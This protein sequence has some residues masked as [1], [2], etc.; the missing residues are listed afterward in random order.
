MPKGGFVSAAP[1][2]HAVDGGYRKRIVEN[3][4]EGKVKTA[5]GK[6]APPPPP[7]PLGAWLETQL[8]ELR[9][10]GPPPSPPPLG[11]W[12]EMQ[13]SELSM[14]GAGGAQDDRHVA[15]AQQDLQPAP[16]L[17]DGA[18]GQRVLAADA[19]GPVTPAHMMSARGWVGGWVGGLRG[20]K[21]EDGPHYAWLDASEQELPV[22]VQGWS[23]REAP[24]SPASVIHAGIL[25][26]AA[27]GIFN[28][29]EVVSLQEEPAEVVIVGGGPHALA[30]LAA[31][32]EGSRVVVIDPGS[33]F[34]QSW[35]TRFEALEISHL[36]SPAIAHPVA[37]D[38]TALVD[39]AI[40]EGRTSELIE[41]PVSGSWLVSTDV[42]REKWLKALP[43]SALF[44]DFC[45]S[46]AAK[47]PHRFCSGTATSVSK[48][49]ET[50]EFRVHYKTTVDKREHVVPARA[51]ILATGPVGKW[52]IPAPFEP[53]LASRL[54]LHTEELL[55]ES[56]GTLREEITR[57]CADET[58][59]WG[60]R[61]RGV[62][63]CLFTDV[64][65]H[66]IAGARASPLECSSL[67]A[68]SVRH[69]R[70]SPPFARAI[71]SYCALVD[72]CRPVLLIST[73][74]GSTCARPTEC[75]S[76]SCACR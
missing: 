46:L 57:R 45:S 49:S 20:L 2:R 41:A 44:R 6:A 63:G 67:A 54:V 28:C 76:S 14:G 23:K 65:Y 62:V 48:D 73:T 24:A 4:A 69:R 53:H 12:L 9:M 31:L 1:R 42:D 29:T 8:S 47:L 50:G 21:Y 71:K 5:R 18:L 34:M 72:L 52:N 36:R 37:F 33:H 10:G 58:R 17:R 35:N 74:A 30:A 75:G 19:L 56:K 13:F 15:P 26:P 64:S 39:F 22:R 25:P 32:D 66:I 3:A 61:L 16:E 38:P 55:A 43:S 11:A 59:P 60:L 27:P 70:R 68:A 7:A 40:G 51:V